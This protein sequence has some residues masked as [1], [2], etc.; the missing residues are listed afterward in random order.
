[1]HIYFNN[2][3]MEIITAHI[4]VIY[5][6]VQTKYILLDMAALGIDNKLE[7]FWEGFASSTDVFLE[8]F[9]PHFLEESEEVRFLQRFS[10]VALINF[11]V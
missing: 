2:H 9:G 11:W 7:T 8:N 5:L 3:D 10:L 1:M 6:T 4:V